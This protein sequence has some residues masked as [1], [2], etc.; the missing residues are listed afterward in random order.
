VDVVV[1]LYVVVDVN[2]VVVVCLYAPSAGHAH[3]YDSD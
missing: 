1:D 3:D 2:A